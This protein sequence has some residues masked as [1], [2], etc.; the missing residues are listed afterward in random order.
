ML[1]IPIPFPLF[2]KMRGPDDMNDRVSIHHSVLYIQERTDVPLSGTVHHH[3]IKPP[4]DKLGFLI[5]IM[6]FLIRE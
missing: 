5:G 1:T 6:S 2:T 4:T 3:M